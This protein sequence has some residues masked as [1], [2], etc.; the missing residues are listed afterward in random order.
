MN[1]SFRLRAKNNR[2]VKLVFKT[3]WIGMYATYADALSAIPSEAHI[4]YN[5]QDTIKVFCE[6]PIDKVRP[7]DYPVM[8]HLRGILKPGD[9]LIDLGGSTGMMC[10]TT[11]KYFT[12][13]EG[14]E[15]IVCDVPK[16]V[17]AGLLVAERESDKS[18]P[19]RFVTSL[20]EAGKGRI[21][22]TSGALQY[23]EKPLPELLRELPTLPEFLLINRI[24]A[25]N[26]KA[27]STIQDIGFCLTPYQIFNRAEFVAS[28]EALGYELV[29]TWS[30]PESTFSVRFR[31]NIRLHAYAGFFFRQRA[32]S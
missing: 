8:L 22:F 24:P 10:Y 32:G 30:C 21:F 29:D 12:L 31:P 23:I 4:G 25:R 28:L 14:V 15:W 13:P 19:L 26:Q 27:F 18:S 6:Y 9:R 17:Q 1:K 3:P 7:A 16:M 11:Q 2:L 20:A 5:Q